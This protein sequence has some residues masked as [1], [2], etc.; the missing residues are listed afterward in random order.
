MTVLILRATV[1]RPLIRICSPTINVPEVVFNVIVALLPPPFTA[2]P[3]A[4]LLRPSTNAV[5]GNSVLDIAVFKT[6][7]VN[8]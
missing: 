1:V 5:S 6:K 7:L 3:E 2:K 4:P 8:V